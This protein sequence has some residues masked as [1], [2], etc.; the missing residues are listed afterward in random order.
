MIPLKDST[1][2]EL[3]VGDLLV[4]SSLIGLVVYKDEV[5][6]IFWTKPAKVY[7]YTLAC[8]FTMDYWTAFELQR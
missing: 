2:Q 4:S 7:T 1:E 8:T 6:Q 3:E 5:I